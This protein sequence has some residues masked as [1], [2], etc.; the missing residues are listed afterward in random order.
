MV[1]ALYGVYL[2]CFYFAGKYIFFA[3]IRFSS[4]LIAKKK[5]CLRLVEVR[6]DYSFVL[7][8][9]FVCSYRGVLMFWISQKIYTYNLRGCFF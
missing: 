5:L 1:D 6:F 7:V 4:R 9:G 8:I 3:T 2:S